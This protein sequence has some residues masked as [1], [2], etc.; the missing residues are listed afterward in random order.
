MVFFFLVYGS[1]WQAGFQGKVLFCSKWV[2]V[3]QKRKETG[4][5]REKKKKGITQSCSYK[6]D[7]ELGLLGY[8]CV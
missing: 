3:N 5:E 7:V 6:D 8:F 2:R 1:I 4:R